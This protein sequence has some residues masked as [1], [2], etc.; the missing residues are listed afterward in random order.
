MTIQMIYLGFVIKLSDIRSIF[1]KLLDHCVHVFGAVCF[2]LLWRMSSKLLFYLWCPIKVPFTLKKKKVRLLLVHQRL[3]AYGRKFPALLCGEWF[4]SLKNRSRSFMLKRV[5][6]SCKSLTFKIHTLNPMI[7]HV[8]THLQNS[9]F[10]YNV[11]SDWSIQENQ[12]Y[13]F[14]VRGVGWFS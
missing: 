4:M 11:K 1:V 5:P 14:I 7:S 9:A 10:G 8:L 13:Y 6:L 2:D 3:Q 12:I